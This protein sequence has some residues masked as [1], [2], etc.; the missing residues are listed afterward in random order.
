MAVVQC[1]L[2]AGAD[3]ENANHDGSTPSHFAAEQGHRAVV[4][5]LL[6][7]G[8]DKEMADKD[9]ATPLYFAAWGVCG[10]CAVLA[11]CRC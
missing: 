11:G 5:C 4:H 3:K 6:D 10:S 8:A 1:L 9:G 2:D 7:A